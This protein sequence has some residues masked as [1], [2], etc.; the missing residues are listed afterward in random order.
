MSMT[1]ASIR[2]G[3]QPAPDRIIV[4]GTEA[5][6]KS[7][8]ASEAPAPIF[9]AAEDGIRKLDVSAYPEP[10]TF[11]DVMEA[12]A[13]LTTST[14]SYKTLAIDTIDWVAPLIID[15]V[16]AREKWSAEDFEKFG[17][18]Y[19]IWM[20]EWRQLLAA[21]DRLRLEKGMEIILL[22]HAK[23]GNF[24]N[25]TGDDYMRYMLPIGGEAAPALLMAWADTVLFAAFEE[26]TVGDPKAGRVKGVSSGKHLLH[27]ERT[28]AWDAKNRD[29][30]PPIIP[31]SYA[32]FDA[33]RKGGAAPD[34][35]E[36][37]SECMRLA[38]N[39]VEAINYIEQNKTDVKAL[40]RALNS[41]RSA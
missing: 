19:R 29:G 11:A 34:V 2:K 27:T 8:F 12:I 31:L 39:N 14:H 40:M 7:T 36:L 17:R 21:L 5:I 25:P 13:D 10:K 16:R 15:A 1:L 38:E 4:Y 41:L 3:K 6:G 24:K 23:V 33:A 37:Y 35:N 32:E 30:L 18:G 20:T 28:A 26:F 22:S 9:V